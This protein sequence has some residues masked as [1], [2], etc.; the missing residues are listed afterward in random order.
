MPPDPGSDAEAPGSGDRGSPSLVDGADG[1]LGDALHAI[2]H[3]TSLIHN[4]DAK[5]GLGAAAIAGLLAIASQQADS[6]TT[7]MSAGTGQE[8]AALSVL[9]ALA[10]SLIVTAVATGYALIPRT[11]L[12][13]D[14]GRFSYPTVA[15]ADWRFQPVDR[16]QATAE[17]WAQA[18]TLAEIASRKFAGVRVALLAL[19]VTFA[20]CCAW[21]GLAV[22]I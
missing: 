11:P 21:T 2:S 5:A 10:I 9:I 16:T 4:A 13:T 14:G 18:K 6:I 1:D 7:A 15:S 8:Q 20:L 12:G 19:G 3:F 22:A 17:A